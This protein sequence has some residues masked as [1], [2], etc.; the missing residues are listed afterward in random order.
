MTTFIPPLGWQ[1]SYIGKLWEW[2]ARGPQSFDCW[3]FVCGVWKD[4]YNV[5]LPDYLDQTPKDAE[6]G[7]RYRISA[8]CLTA[9][10]DIMVS[11][12]SP[13]PL[14]LVLMRHNSVPS[15]IGLYAHGGYIVHACEHAQRV[16]QSPRSD[17]SARIIGYYWPADFLTDAS[18]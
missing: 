16:I 5:D 1:S 7:D 6:A 17:I 2:R 3:G 14:A 11:I 4:L 8:R 13:R 18:K 9:G 12:E 10:Q 15:H